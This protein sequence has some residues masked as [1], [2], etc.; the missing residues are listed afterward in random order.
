M[1]YVN[2]PSKIA[3]SRLQSV[4]VPRDDETRCPQQ[5]V[6]EITN[7]Q[8]DCHQ[9]VRSELLSPLTVNHQYQPIPKHR[10]HTWDRNIDH[11][12][13]CHLTQPKVQL[14]SYLR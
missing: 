3:L 2:F 12:V 8:I 14:S 6:A 4:A 13:N 9:L 1:L 10:H 11:S 5:A 7:S